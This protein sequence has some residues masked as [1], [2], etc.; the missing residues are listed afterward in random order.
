MTVLF[1]LLIGWYIITLVMHCCI[2]KYTKDEEEEKEDKDK[3]KESPDFAAEEKD[4]KKGL[5]DFVDD[6]GDAAEKNE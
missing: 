6:D 4:K 2:K 1:V 5:P 3:K